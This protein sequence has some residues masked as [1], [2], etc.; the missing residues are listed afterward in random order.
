MAELLALTES[1]YYILLALYRP[2]HGYGI[3]QEVERLSSGRVR[4]AAGT[5]Y[6][7]LTSMTEKGWIQMLPVEEGS[8]KK[9]YKLTDKGIKILVTEI[10]RLRE[11]V[12]NGDMIIGGDN[13][14]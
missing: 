7:A 11:L 12:K 1:T 8:R 2:Q 13:N 9:E 10:E 5:L 14:G 6:G 3:M 4:L